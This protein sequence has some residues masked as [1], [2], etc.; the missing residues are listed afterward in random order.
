M[1]FQR[2]Q[3]KSNPQSD[4]QAPKSAFSRSS[5]REASDTSF[6]HLRG[7][8]VTVEGELVNSAARNTRNKVFVGSASNVRT[9]LCGA[10]LAL[11]GKEVG[12]KTSNVGRSHGGAR[13]GV[14]ISG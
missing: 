9:E 4:F 6:R 12:T 2:P 14:L 1:P 8:R 7:R 13:D 5:R 3:L 10:L 11:E